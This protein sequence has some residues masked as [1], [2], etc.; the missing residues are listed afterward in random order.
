[1]EQISFQYPSWFSVLALIGALIFAFLLYYK[2]KG[3]DG[4]RGWLKPVLYTLRFIPI[5]GIGLLL[6][7]PLIK[8]LLEETK[9]P[10]V[11][12][13]SDDSRSINQW[14]ERSETT[15][16]TSAMSQLA[17][18][19]SESYDIEHY[20][21]GEDIQLISEDTSRYDQ[22]ITDISKT[23][24]YISD[25]YEGENLGAV[26]LATD[27][28]YNQGSNPTYAKIR[29]DIPIHSI[30]LGDTTRRRDISVETVLH[31]EVA[32]LEDEM[33]TR[34]DIK[35]SNAAGRSARLSVERETPGGYQVVERRDIKVSGDDYFTSEDIQLQLN[36]AGINHFRYS[37]SYIDNELNR[38]NNTKDVYIEVLDARQKISIIAA[39]PHPDISA[40]KQILEQNKNY[41]VD[42]FIK[43]VAV[44]DIGSTDVAI[45]HNLPSSTVSIDNILKALSR[46]SV[47]KMFIVGQDTDLGKWNNVQDQL[48]I[49]G[50][51]GNANNA[52]GS[53]NQDFDYFTISDELKN[54]VKDFPPLASPY[55][56]YSIGGQSDVMLYQRIGDIGTEFPL[57]AFSDADGSKTAY[58]LANDIWRWKLYDHLQHSNFDIISE[59][60]EKSITYI[61]TKEDKRKFRV[62][63]NDNVFLTNEDVIFTAELYNNN[64]ELINDPEVTLQMTSSDGSQFDYTFSTTDQAYAL[65]IGRLPSG[66]YNYTASTTW[67]GE[68]YKDAGRI[69][70][71]D[72]QFELYDQEARHELLYSLA[73][74]TGGSV[75]YPTNIAS[76]GTSLLSSDKIKPVIY[77]STVTKPLLDN[78]WLLLFLIIP[79]ILEWALRRYFGSL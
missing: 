5:L 18:N 75:T 42:I 22:E 37:I 47:A 15:D 20:S 32:Y 21:F 63:T 69:V 68:K 78:K 6:L 60:L 19:L 62:G 24:K 43:D 14:V 41:E 77:Q 52:Q 44:T 61:S 10:V 76:L 53:L 45:F 30:A 48:T 73:E 38:S 13:L 70:V 7:G 9:K 79:L 17:Q 27:G 8:Q 59:L 23:L 12:L 50:S 72:I 34:V 36:Q 54:Q 51:R 57:L 11:V 67:S 55:G 29:A 31:N 26:V 46:Q 49:K 71:R 3:F 58:L 64:Y 74:R 16:P 2:F 56:E 1:V 4:K 35:A 28:I 39:A 40:I 65:D 33:I 25:V 66:T